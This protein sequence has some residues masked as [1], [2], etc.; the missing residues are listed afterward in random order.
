MICLTF[1]LP[2]T[3]PSSFCRPLGVAGI[4]YLVCCAPLILPKHWGLFSFI[5]DR[6]EDL[7]TELHIEKGFKYIGMPIGVM[8]MTLGLD[9]TSIVKIRRK[10]RGFPQEVIGANQMEKDNIQE[11]WETKRK[12]TL[13]HPDS[14][15]DRTAHLWGRQ[16]INIANTSSFDGIDLES[17]RGGHERS[18]RHSRGRRYSEPVDDI[19]NHF[20]P[21][22][23]DPVNSGHERENSETESVRATR[24]VQGA[25]PSTTQNV[26]IRASSN[27]SSSLSPTMDYSNTFADVWPVPPDEILQEGDSLFLSVGLNSLLEFQKQASSVLKLEGLR[28]I[29]CDALD[30]PG[31]GTDFF[32]VVI[33]PQNHFVGLDGHRIPNFERHFKCSILALRKRGEVEP[34][35]IHGLRTN[36]CSKTM[37]SPNSSHHTIPKK[38]CDSDSKSDHINARHISG[39]VSIMLSNRN[40]YPDLELHR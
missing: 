33:S 40:W 6:T 23:F 13:Y 32:E 10:V 36:F 1:S 17:M 26:P 12:E 22:S 4:L 38:K 34:E 35:T 21:S 28:F 25:R 18:I 2:H 14:Y 39:F 30:I 27:D 9:H 3:L 37:H 29:A 5:R 16:P 31:K 20:P 7:V 15:R 19:R 24:D 8:L 11:Y